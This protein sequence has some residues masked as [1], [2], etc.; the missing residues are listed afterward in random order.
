MQ[1]FGERFDGARLAGTSGTEEQEH[2]C[3]PTLRRESGA[4]H[5]AAIADDDEHLGKH[6]GADR[7]HEPDPRSGEQHAL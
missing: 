3:W 6:H 4:M 7:M 1:D 2:T 5:Q